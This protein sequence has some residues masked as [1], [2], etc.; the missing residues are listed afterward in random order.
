[1][2]TAM[3]LA[4]GRGT[5]LGSLTQR[6]P[7]ILVDIEERLAAASAWLARFRAAY[8]DPDV[9]GVGGSIEPVSLGGRPRWFP[10]EFA[11]VVGCSHRGL[12]EPPAPVTEPHRLQH[13]VS[14]CRNRRA[15][16]VPARVR[17]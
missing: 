10:D 9:F 12:P 3:I 17:V 16:R 2:V 11:W 8:A 6:I 13:V 14:S 1:M 5:R 4:A 7:K 15:R